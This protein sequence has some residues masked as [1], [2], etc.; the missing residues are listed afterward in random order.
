MEAVWKLTVRS[1]NDAEGFVLGE[2]GPLRE[3]MEAWM[4]DADGNLTNQ[5]V[6]SVTGVADEFRRGPL[7]ISMVADEIKAMSL[8]REA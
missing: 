1:K 7:T 8:S 6:W 2:E 3:A 4:A 5:K